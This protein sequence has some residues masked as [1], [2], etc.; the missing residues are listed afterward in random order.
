MYTK[1]S[2]NSVKTLDTETKSHTLCV[3]KNGSLRA[4]S[5]TVSIGTV[6]KRMAERNMAE[7]NMNIYEV[8]KKQEQGNYF[9]S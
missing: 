1:A 4:L 7:K 8:C 2:A 5:H 3:R 6:Q 9:A